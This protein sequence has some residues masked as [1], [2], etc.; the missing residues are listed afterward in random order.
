MAWSLLS[1]CVC[2]FFRMMYYEWVDE[3]K[4]V[5]CSKN[6]KSLFRFMYVRDVHVHGASISACQELTCWLVN[7]YRRGQK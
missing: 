6:G 1:F 4:C 2:V 7:L 3:A 5:G